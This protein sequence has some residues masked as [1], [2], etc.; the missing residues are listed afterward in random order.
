MPMIN[1]TKA[2]E[3]TGKQRPTICKWISTYRVGNKGIGHLSGGQYLIDKDKLLMVQNGEQPELFKMLISEYVSHLSD[4]GI[5]IATVRNKEVFLNILGSS[6]TGIKITPGK[7]QRK[8]I[9]L[10][11]VLHLLTELGFE[12]KDAKGNKLVYVL[13]DLSKF[14]KY[15]PKRLV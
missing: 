13:E 1:T 11:E 15:I 4:K 5:P 12:T 3:I 7:Y 2:M 8:H 10:E 6:G 9:S 14:E